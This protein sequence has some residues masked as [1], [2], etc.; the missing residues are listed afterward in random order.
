M[1][2]VPAGT[3]CGHACIK[4]YI[5]DVYA[6]K[7]QAK[8][9]DDRRD[10]KKRKDALKTKGDW[11]SEA[12]TAFNRWIRLRDKD[13]PCISCGRHHS[14][15]YHA[16]HYRTVGSCPEL[17]F[18]PLQVHKQCSPC[19]LHLSGN[20][21]EYRKNLIG[22]VGQDMVDWIEGPHEMPHRTIDDIK[23]IK[24]KYLAKCRELTE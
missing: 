14:G 13:R 8:A 9:K 19:N 2:K 1:I 17:R 22:V 12:Q 4:A 10:L 16:G 7:S 20:I 11:L 6:K 15:Q 5:D 3:F 23:A 21:L 18:E 24:I